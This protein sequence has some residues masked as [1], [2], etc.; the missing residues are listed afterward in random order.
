MVSV[1]SVF[2]AIVFYN[3]A[4]IAVYCLMR[5]TKFVINYTAASLSLLTLLAILRLF[6]PADF[7]S[8]FVIEST[9]IIPAV[10]GFISQPISEGSITVGTLLAILWALGT[11][12]YLVYD[13]YLAYASKKAERGFIYVSNEQV[14][15]A[16]EELGLKYPVKVSPSIVEP[17]SAGII[18]PA[19]YLPDWDLGE[20]ELKAILNH[21]YQHIRSFDA[22]KKLVFLLLEALFW[23]NPISH[24]F[25]QELNQLL[26]IQCDYKMTAG[27]SEKSRLQYAEALLSVMRRVTGSR[28]G[29]LCSCSL[30]N[31][32]K[33]MK[34]RFELI[35]ETGN[36]KVRYTKIILYIALIS[37]FALSF[38]IIAQPY[39]APPMSSIDGVCIIDKDNSFILKAGDEYILYC[40]G[41]RISSIGKETLSDQVM[42]ELPIYY[43]TD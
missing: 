19:I 16:A 42:K 8:A 11:L 3:I 32:A 14:Q 34:Q 26:E 36:S 2:S 35:L 38:F 41:E 29:C 25:R 5:R 17:Y 30:T 20:Q 18:R 37:V 7:T 23:W 6:I 33:N 22:L 21:E 10:Q 15:R 43:K 12:G 28:K 24:I 1:Y 27:K 39:Y 9:R 13:L 4:L 40:N 31:S